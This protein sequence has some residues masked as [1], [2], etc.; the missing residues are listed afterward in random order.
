MK[1]STNSAQD[2]QPPE[3]EHDT[4]PAPAPVSTNPPPPSALS[5]LDFE[6]A[7][8]SPNTPKI[9]DELNSV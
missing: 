4:I 9:E 8:H 2:E 6:M 7:L 1:E 3:L 5:L